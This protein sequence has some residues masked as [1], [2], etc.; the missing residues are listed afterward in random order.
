MV[1]VLLQSGDE[2]RAMLACH[3][4]SVPRPGGHGDLLVSIKSFSRRGAA[5]AGL[6]PLPVVAAPPRPPAAVHLPLPRRAARL[7]ELQVGPS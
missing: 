4:G 1:D 2:L 3:Q 7:L 5:P 6:A